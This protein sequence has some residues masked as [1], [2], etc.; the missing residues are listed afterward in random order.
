MKPWNCNIFRVSGR[1][2]LVNVFI[3]R[4]KGRG[5]EFF[6]RIVESWK[7]NTLS[8]LILLPCSIWMFDLHKFV[9]KEIN[10]LH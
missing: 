6:I 5:G 9:L 4:W 3:P 8:K 2:R 10:I 1:L 7:R